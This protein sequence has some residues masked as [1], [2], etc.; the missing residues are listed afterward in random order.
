MD[1]DRI[2]D[3]LLE[4]YQ[5]E[6][7]KR[8]GQG[9][10]GEVHQAAV[11]GVACAIKISLDEID[12]S[13]PDLAV[14]LR[15][16]DIA[17][18]VTG[19]PRIVTLIDVWQ[20]PENG[21]QRHLVTRWELAEMSLLDRVRECQ[22]QGL[23]GIPRDELIGYMRDVAEGIDFLNEQKG[24]YHRDIKPG[25]LLLFQGHAKLADFGLAKF[26]GASGTHNS[27]GG[28]LGYTP[29][30]ALQNR[31]HPTIDVYSLAA[32]YIRLR[33][34]HEPFGE[35]RGNVVDIL[36]RQKSGAP[37]L[38]G[39]AADEMEAVRRALAGNT[40]DRPF[41]TAAEWLAAMSP[42]TPETPDPSVLPSRRRAVVDWTKRL[43]FVFLVLSAVMFLVFQVRQNEFLV[44]PGGPAPVESDP[45]V[46]MLPKVVKTE[47]RPDE[48]RMVLVQTTERVQ[49]GTPPE[50][51]RQFSEAGDEKLRSVK[52]PLY[53]WISETE[54]TQAQYQSVVNPGQEVVNGDWPQTNV[55]FFDAINACNQFSRRDRLEPFYRMESIEYS[56]SD[57]A[58]IVSA[59]VS[60]LSGMNGYRLPTEAEWESCCRAGSAG[61][62]CF[63]NDKSKLGEFAWYIDNSD[64]RIHPVANRRKNS[65]GLFDMHGNVLE[66]VWDVRRVG[67]RQLRNA[68]GGH[69]GARSDMTRSARIDAFLPHVSRGFLG[70]RIVRDVV[71]HEHSVLD[72]HASSEGE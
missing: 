18:S 44:S 11:R 5:V 65:L 21:P 38:D 45:R 39:L 51:R 30:E 54:I 37:M 40:V 41:A 16:L 2:F 36:D 67:S 28:T 34:G 29:P 19:H 1:P 55:T 10:F 33:T 62:W 66:W 20:V 49:I 72:R 9:A 59:L 60:Q 42:N 69:V 50:R 15:E 13:Q 12:D 70:F 4:R 46:H 31:H 48:M 56:E 52:I 6:R 47:I 61:D 27:G 14:Q 3:E 35:E 17:K 71:G 23:S 25:N 7:V 53:L 58:S 22:Q 26:V 32:T 64:S 24:I 43:V 8:I 57:P 68:R 63:G